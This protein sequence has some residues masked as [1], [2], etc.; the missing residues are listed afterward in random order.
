MSNIKKVSGENFEQ[1][2]L[3]SQV[4]TLVDFWAPWCGP[5][6]LIGPI[7]ESLATAN[8]GV[9]NVAKINVDE[10]QDLAREYGIRGIP[11]LVLFKDGEEVKRIVGLQ[12][13]SQIQETIDYV[14]G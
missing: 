11:T 3:Q 10:N 9:L 12:G 7:V 13:K 5:C 1:E 4:P 14:I 2:V 8:E 6:K